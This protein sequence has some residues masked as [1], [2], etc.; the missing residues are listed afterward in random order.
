MASK[1]QQLESRVAKLEKELL[2]LKARLRNGDRV[3][4]YEQIVGAFKNDPAYA[5]ITRLGQ[6]IR[7]AE[8]RRKR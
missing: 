4:W 5:E 1:V 8:R 7:R 6:A 3:P 2:E